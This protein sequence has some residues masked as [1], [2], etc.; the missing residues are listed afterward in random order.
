MLKH[1][2]NNINRRELTITAIFAVFAALLF[3]PLF[4]LRNLGPID[5][6]WWMSA[7]LVLLIASGGIVDRNYWRTL[8]TDLK[9]KL[10]WKIAA[11]LVAAGG[12]FLVFYFGNIM[13]RYLFTM[14]GSDIKAIYEFKGDAATLKII[15]L[16]AIVIGPGEEIFWRGFLQRRLTN[17]FGDI[18]GLATATFL[19][20]LVHIAS[21]NAIL[22]LAALVCGVFWGYLY[23]R[24]GSIT[25]NIVSHTVWDI[26]VFAIFPFTG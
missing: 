10:P 12:L 22:V 9:G 25:I 6:W 13:S 1:V 24:Y 14:A 26:A 19:Y 17:Q 4:H 21:G 11:G 18:K 7:V 5:F 23:H 8:R 15:I 16:M 2:S 20:A 3:M